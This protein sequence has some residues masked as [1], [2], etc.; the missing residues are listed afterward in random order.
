MAWNRLYSSRSQ[1]TYRLVMRSRRMRC[2]QKLSMVGGALSVSLSACPTE[3]CE[4]RQDVRICKVRLGIQ[5]VL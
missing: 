1:E 5:G 3:R 4:A 2:K